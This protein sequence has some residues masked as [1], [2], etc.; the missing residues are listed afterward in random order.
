M[1]LEKFKIKISVA[2]RGILDP[3]WKWDSAQGQE[4]G[5]VLWVIAKGKG[6]LTEEDKTYKLSPGTCLILRPQDWHKGR[7]DPDNPLVV[8]WVI[9]DFI[10]KKGNI[11][12]PSLKEL[13]KYRHMRHI[14][15]TVNLFN[16]AINA[17]NM[18]DKVT[19][20]VWLRAVLQEIID[21]DEFS[22]LTGLE[23]EQSKAIDLLCS[24][25]NN[26]PERKFNIN[27]FADEMH[28]TPDHF[29][30]MFKRFKGITPV[31]FIIKA[32]ITRACQ[33]LS[34]SNL[35]IGQIANKL[36]YTDQYF[37]SKQF[38]SITGVPPREFRKLK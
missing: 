4:S 24:E 8:P 23:L 36:G 3:D 14:D 16:R 35:D 37:F 30:R 27:D 19:A 25:I 32:R 28:C 13:P 15:F 9:L 7:H 34:F 1:K 5:L 38:K 22:S 17:F 2:D 29:I 26:F 10:D 18:G 11:F 21:N 6:T 12:I 20:E 31:K 33:L